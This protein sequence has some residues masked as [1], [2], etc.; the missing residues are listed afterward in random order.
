MQEI[1]DAM[2][3]GLLESFDLHGFNI[4]YPGRLIMHDTQFIRIMVFGKEAATVSEGSYKMIFTVNSRASFIQK[5][6][7]ETLRKHGLFKILINNEK[8]NSYAP[9]EPDR[10]MEM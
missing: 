6:A 5:S 2:D 4:K 1:C 3:N 10:S 8:F 7:L 9:V